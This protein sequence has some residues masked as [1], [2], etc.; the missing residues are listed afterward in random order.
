MDQHASSPHVVIRGFL[1]KR[2]DGKPDTGFTAGNALARWSKRY[3]V[4]TQEDGHLSYYRDSGDLTKPA[5]YI[6]VGA[7]ELK[8]LPPEPQP[9]AHKLVAPRPSD[10]VFVVVTGARILTLAATDE[11]ELG[12]WVGAINLVRQQHQARLNHVLAGAHVHSHD[13]S[14]HASGPQHQ[15]AHTDGEALSG[16]LERAASAQKVEERLDRARVAAT[17]REQQ[18]GL[19]PRGGEPVHL[20]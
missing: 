3:F 9:F 11:T 10:Y 20:S 5:G 6:E 7:C 15:A 19:Q 8:R 1:H 4:L 13:S 17:R 12:Q 2:S 18:Q 16:S 14:G